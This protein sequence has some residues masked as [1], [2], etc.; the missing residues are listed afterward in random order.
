[1]LHIGKSYIVRE[2]GTSRL[3]ADLTIGDR[4]TTLWFSVDSAQE[5]YLAPG[6][7]DPFVMAALPAAMRGKH[8]ITC[9]DPMSERLHHQLV[10]GLI[11][12]LA[13]AGGL[14]HLIKITAPL[15]AKQVPNQGAVGTGFSGGVD[16]LY[17]VMKHGADSEYPLT[18]IAIF[19]HNILHKRSNFVKE[20]RSSRA[21]KAGPL[22]GCF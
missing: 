16:S 17:T 3:C 22:P 18:H 12:T 7:A 6:R 14:Y 9:E 15:T 4:R 10:N 19:C 20:F 1:M 2:N 11:P 13:F 8:E 5:E 21:R